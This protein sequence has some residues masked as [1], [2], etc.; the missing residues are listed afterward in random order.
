[1]YKDA[2][3]PVGAQENSRKL[4]PPGAFSKVEGLVVGGRN[5]DRCMLDMRGSH[6]IE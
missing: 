1:M 5:K 3:T 6:I 2:M 4:T